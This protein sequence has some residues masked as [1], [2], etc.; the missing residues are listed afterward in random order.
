MLTAR[1]F[2]RFRD[3]NRRSAF[4]KKKA[5]R[6]EAPWLKKTGWRNLQ[7]QSGRRRHLA[8]PV[9]DAPE[10]SNL[11]TRGFKREQPGVQKLWRMPRSSPVED[12]LGAVAAPLSASDAPPLFFRRA[13]VPYNAV[14]LLN[15]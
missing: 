4:A 11:G 14:R 9:P 12:V 2:R 10:P 15:W 1:C 13:Q 8:N 6:L 7:F 3:A 5:T